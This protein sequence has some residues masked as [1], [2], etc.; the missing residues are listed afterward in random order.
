MSPSVFRVRL[1][2]GFSLLANGEAL[3]GVN[4]VRL[5][6]LLAYL[7]L[8][9]DRTQSRQQIAFLLSDKASFMTGE[10]VYVSGGPRMSNRE[11]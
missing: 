8:H 2:G 9:A 7:V 6:S 3:T 5:Q 4:S 10:T 11:D 1:L